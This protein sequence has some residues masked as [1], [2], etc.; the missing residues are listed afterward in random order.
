MN[1][2][3]TRFGAVR[4]MSAGEIDELLNHGRWGVLALISG[5]EPY[6]VPVS[7]GWDGCCFFIAMLPGGRKASALAENP[8][9]CFTVVDSEPGAPWRSVVAHGR[10]SWVEDLP[11]KIAAFVALRRQHGKGEGPSLVEAA[12]LAAQALILRIKPDI[13]SGRTKSE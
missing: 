4:A 3:K 13:L 12:R 2:T 8:A 9:A 1:A 10:G 6:A 11:G 5:G 7:Y